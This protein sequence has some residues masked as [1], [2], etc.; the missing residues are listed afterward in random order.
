MLTRQAEHGDQEPKEQEDQVLVPVSALWSEGVE[1]G[2]S[3][4][5]IL[6]E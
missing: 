1:E 2:T 5:G 4:D 3:V 6:L